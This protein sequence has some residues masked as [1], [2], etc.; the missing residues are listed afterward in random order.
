MSIARYSDAP[1]ASCDNISERKALA[2]DPDVTSSSDVMVTMAT[3]DACIRPPLVESKVGVVE[4][5]T[6]IQG[7]QVLLLVRLFIEG[8]VKHLILHKT[9]GQFS[10]SL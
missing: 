2:L 10:K 8:M 3:K 1:A 7:T 5:V 6:T 4:R 9:A